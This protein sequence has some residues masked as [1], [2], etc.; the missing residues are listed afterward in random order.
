MHG[1]DVPD[2]YRW[3]EDQDSPAT[4]A[5]ID[6][7]NAYTRAVLD[8]VPDRAGLRQSVMVDWAGD[9][10]QRDGPTVRGARYFFQRRQAGQSNPSI[11]VRQGL[12]G[13]ERGPGGSESPVP[14][15]V[16]AGLSLACIC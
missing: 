14:G 12:E 10:V 8:A 9:T 13:P 16:G 7:E 11:V 4:R 1:I 15:R 3:L 2:P 6:A 5:W